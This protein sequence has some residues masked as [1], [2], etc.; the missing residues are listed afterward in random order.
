[1]KSIYKKLRKT[2]S[3]TLAGIVLASAPANAGFFK[4]VVNTLNPFYGKNWLIK[5]AKIGAYLGT[6]YLV[7]AH[8]NKK[9]DSDLIPEPDPVP[10]DTDGD[11]IPDDQDDDDDND[12]MPDAWE[13]QYGLDIK[14]DNSGK[15]T[16]NDNYTD[17]E[18]YTEGSDPTDPDSNPQD[19]SRL[20]SPRYCAKTPGITYKPSVKI[21]IADIVRQKKH[22][23]YSLP[24]YA[25][26]K[27]PKNSR[28]EISGKAPLS[29]RS[30]YNVMVKGHIRY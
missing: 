4:T 11:G 12:G 27:G 16:D 30:K 24:F 21:N 17:L 10:V 22:K 6:G 1:M 23:N 15:D 19:D 7:Y 8:N 18:E 13:K 3:L 25:C 28:I 26:F 14:K 2:G 29:K 5:G 9:S 20:L